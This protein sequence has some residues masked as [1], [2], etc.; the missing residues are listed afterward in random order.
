MV[1]S[2]TM[3]QRAPGIDSFLFNVF[4]SESLNAFFDSSSPKD[5]GCTMVLP[6]SLSIVS[7]SA[8]GSCTRIPEPVSGVSEEPLDWPVWL[9]NWTCID[10]NEGVGRSAG[11]GVRVKRDG[12]GVPDRDGVRDRAGVAYPLR[13][14]D[15]I[16][17]QLTSDPID[18]PALPCA[19]YGISFFQ[20]WIPN[21]VR[22]Y[23]VLG[24][25][26]EISCASASAKLPPCSG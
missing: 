6:A 7:T 16:E 13:L 5:I 14:D 18:R 25:W 10:E 12:V 22:T 3:R 24:C 8:S 26:S 17:P 15:M 9:L 11:V 21:A 23:A 2:R 4:R 20:C 19:Q 1:T